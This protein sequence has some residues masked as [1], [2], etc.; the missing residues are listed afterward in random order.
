V[1]GPCP[2][3]AVGMTN[4][5][6]AILTLAL[7]AA[8]ACTGCVGVRSSQEQAQYLARKTALEDAAT[9][10][11]S[12][13]RNQFPQGGDPGT[14]EYQ[15]P[16]TNRDMVQRLAAEVDDR[17][18]GHEDRV[19]LVEVVPGNPWVGFLGAV[20]AA[21]TRTVETGGGLSYET[22]TATTCV[23][24]EIHGNSSGAGPRRVST[25]GIDCPPTVATVTSRAP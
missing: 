22:A 23:R 13:E 9:L 24:F 5:P 1:S 21:L 17:D 2:G 12:V 18:D 19:L 20:E 10:A 25:R 14:P 15:P 6:G 16:W 7:A 8:V 3:H 4:R 11:A